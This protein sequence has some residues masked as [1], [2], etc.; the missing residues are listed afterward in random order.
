MKVGFLITARLK[1]SRLPKKLLLPF[2]GS[3][4]IGF[5]I[6]RLK[7]VPE[8]DEIILC[9][10]IDEQDDEL[11]LI[12]NK[13]EVKCYRGDREDVIKR[14]YEATEE[15]NLDFVLNMTADC[16]LLPIEFIPNYIEFFKEDKPDLIHMFHMPVGLYIS[17]LNPK[18][19]RKVLE[20]KNE[21]ETEYWLYYFL[22]TNLFNVKQLPDKYFAYDP[23]RDYRIAL[24]YAEDHEQL[25]LLHQKIGDDIFHYTA[26]DLI[27][28]LDNN[29]VI[30]QV[31][32]SCNELGK[33]R[34]ENDPN[35]K[36]T[37]KNG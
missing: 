27:E 28:F 35:S 26:K 19:I 10:S 34:T 2:A 29:P 15:Y 6:D 21:G 4:Y 32:I 9:T 1:S 11:E 23:K 37:L 25:T 36:V 13:H 14:L 3:T 31:N 24:D 20:L 12:A 30:A 33:K 8:L 18:A 16:P 17:G 5:L 22:K 7:T